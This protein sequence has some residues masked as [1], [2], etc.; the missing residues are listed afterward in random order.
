MDL[1]TSLVSHGRKTVATV[2]MGCYSSDSKYDRESMLQLCF[3]DVLDSVMRREL[4][5]SRET[6]LEVNK[7]AAAVSTLVSSRIIAPD[8]PTSTTTI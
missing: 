5:L 7:P 6:R 8:W 3:L 4:V 1:A 2:W